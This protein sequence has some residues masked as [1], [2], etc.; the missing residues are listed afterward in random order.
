MVF[1]FECKLL[2]EQRGGFKAVGGTRSKRAMTVLDMGTIKHVLIMKVTVLS[3][4]I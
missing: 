3:V 4:V 1:L 2:V